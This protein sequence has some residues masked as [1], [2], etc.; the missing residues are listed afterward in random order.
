MSNT[1]INAQCGSLE[2]MKSQLIIGPSD[3]RVTRPNN[4]ACGHFL[5]A[6][7]RDARRH[8]LRMH[9]WLF[10]KHTEENFHYVPAV[11]TR[12]SCYKPK[13]SYWTFLTSRFDLMT[14][15][16]TYRKTQRRDVQSNPALMNSAPFRFCW[17]HASLTRP[18][19]LISAR[20]WQDPSLHPKKPA[21]RE[22]AVSQH[23]PFCLFMLSS[24]LSA[25][26]LQQ[27]GAVKLAVKLSLRPIC[28]AIR[29]GYRKPGKVLRGKKKFKIRGLLLANISMKA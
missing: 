18:A 5:F 17:C 1:R 23:L 3:T 13:R 6:L 11:Q 10:S 20:C 7:H 4:A 2:Q 15:R 29:T 19:A 27:K 8:S 25:A 21:A 22:I 16:R 28:S 14:R 26:H 12:S 24:S 9:M